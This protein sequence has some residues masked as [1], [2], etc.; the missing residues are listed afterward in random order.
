[1]FKQA[2]RLLIAASALCVS[3][4]GCWDLHDLGRVLIISGIGVSPGTSQSYKISLAAVNSSEFTPDRKINV[5]QTFVYESESDTLAD[6]FARINRG[7]ALKPEFS[8]VRTLILDETLLKNGDIG[9]FDFIERFKEVRNDLMV[10]AVGKGMVNQVLSAQYSNIS[11]PSYKILLQLSHYMW[12]YG[13]TRAITTNDFIGDLLEPG[14]Q[15]VMPML[16][17]KNPSDKAQSIE[18]SKDSMLK[19]VVEANGLAVF[20]DRRM[21]GSLKGDEVRDYMWTRPE[22]KKTSITFQSGNRC[23][24]TVFLSKIKKKIKVHYEQDQPMIDIRVKTAGQLE[25]S[26]CAGYFQ[27]RSVDYERISARV[28]EEIERSIGRVIDKVQQEYGCDIFGFGSKLRETNYPKY[29]KVHRRWDREFAKAKVHATA[30]VAIIR[31]GIRTKSS[32]K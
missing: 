3:L 18:Y 9:I 4:T 15:P 32:I 8:H 26:Q 24:T 16:V 12:Q 5:A 31:S 22:Q 30:D 25:E 7:L 2:I 1:M 10:A 6:A 27:G 17:L 19:T 29:L 14:I 21:I 20:K 13:G 11:L 28:E 23:F